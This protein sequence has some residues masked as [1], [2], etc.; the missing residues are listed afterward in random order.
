MAQPSDVPL[1]TPLAVISPQ[2]C[3]PQPVELSIVR[4]VLAFGGT[5]AVTDANGNIILKVKPVILF[6]NTMRRVIVDAAGNPIVT[7]KPK[8]QKKQTAQSFFFGKDNFMVTVSPNVDYA[9]IVA[10]IVILDE[11]SKPAS[12]RLG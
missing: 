6:F 2:Y 1:A 9:F 10:L 3:V 4:I 7:L 8:M 12:S 11:I 5:F